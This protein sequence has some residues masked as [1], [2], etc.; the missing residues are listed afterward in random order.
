MCHVC[1]IYTVLGSVSF[2]RFLCWYQQSVL[3]WKLLDAMLL[4]WCVTSCLLC[5]EFSWILLL[6]ASK[7]G[8]N[9]DLVNVKHLIRYK[10][11]KTV[12]QCSNRLNI[13]RHSP[14]L[15]HWRY[16]WAGKQGQ[17]GWNWAEEMCTKDSSL[18]TWQGTIRLDPLRP[19]SKGVTVTQMT[20]V[21]ISI[22]R[23]GRGGSGGN[24]T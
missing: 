3:F 24:T 15:Q 17:Q 21:Q 18:K 1:V 8:P 11:F 12:P 22:K 20:A 16:N 4:F 6:W 5:S 13:F 14:P 10:Y 7:E 19:K 2:L 23:R 9:T